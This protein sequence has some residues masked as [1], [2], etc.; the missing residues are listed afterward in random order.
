MQ[1][2]GEGIQHVALLCDDLVAAVDSLQM[3][4][5]PLMSAPNDVYY[6]ML[7]QRLPGHGEPVQEL[8]TRGIL[9]DGTTKVGRRACCCRSSPK[10][11]S[12]RCSSS[13]SSARPTTA[14]ARATSRRCSRAWSAT[15]CAA[16]RSRALR[17]TLLEDLQALLT[18]TLC[19]SLGVMMLKE[20]GLLTGGTA[21]LAF[22][23]HYGT[24]IS[25]GKLFFLINL[26]FYWLAWRRMGR[27]FTVKTFVAVA[28]L[29]AVS[30]LQPLVLH[31]ESLNPL[32]A[33]AMGGLLI[34]TGFLMLF[35]H[36]ASLGGVGIV[37]LVLQRDRGWRA[38]HVQ[39][40]VDAAILLAALAMVEPSRI[41]YSLVG[42][43]TLN[44]TLA[45]N[46]RPGRYV[47]M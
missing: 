33:A 22:L 26:P 43:L 34:G 12:A 45:V 21:G 38:G 11:C 36:Q 5:V 41:A 30:D 18:G 14:S 39:L 20:V 25:F 15:R 27:L 1:F 46:H 2:N 31:F 9:L 19:I 40:A 37:A 44:L 17:H 4:G 47:A 8:Q 42:A 28:T 6:E 16:A 13:S 23:L 24:G 29:S 3:A 7:E 35:R 32:Y 10:R